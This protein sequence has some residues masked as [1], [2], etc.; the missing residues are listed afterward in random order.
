MPSFNIDVLFQ[1]FGVIFK[2]F[3]CVF[4]RNIYFRLSN[5]FNYLP[6]IKR[7]I[8]ELFFK[9]TVGI[10]YCYYQSRYSLTSVS[11]GQFN[12]IL[13]IISDDLRS[14]H[15]SSTQLPSS[16]LQLFCQFRLVGWK[17]FSENDLSI[18]QPLCEKRKV[19]TCY[20]NIMCGMLELNVESLWSL[21]KSYSYE[22]VNSL[23]NFVSNDSSLTALLFAI[24]KISRKR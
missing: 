4:E 13:S 21:R 7:Y 9:W 17:L 18:V 6:R 5:F 10:Y 3:Y 22:N 2:H 1:C 12:F 15:F 24:D 23:S 16:E 8:I 20:I 11:D 14:E 19:F